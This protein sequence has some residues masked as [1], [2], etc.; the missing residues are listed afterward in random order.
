M[1]GFLQTVA[2]FNY[3]VPKFIEQGFI[4]KEAWV[5]AQKLWEGK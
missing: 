4:S 3:A 5:A 2:F 1:D